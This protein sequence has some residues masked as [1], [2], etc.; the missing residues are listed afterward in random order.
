[1][2]KGQGPYPQQGTFYHLLLLCTYYKANLKWRKFMC[3]RNKTS[4]GKIQSSNVEWHICVSWNRCGTPR[5]DFMCRKF[6]MT[7][8][9]TLTCSENWFV[10]NLSNQIHKKIEAITGTLTLSCVVMHECLST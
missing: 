5:I 10:Y 2:E 7:F 9:I 8:N 1:M 3:I 4:V 6:Y